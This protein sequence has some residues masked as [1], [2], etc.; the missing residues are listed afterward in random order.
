MWH[1]FAGDSDAAVR[2]HLKMLGVDVHGARAQSAPEARRATAAVDA[3]AKRNAITAVRLWQES[4]P[5]D[6][7]LGAR[8][9]ENR[10]IRPPWPGSL[11]YHPR[12]LDRDQQRPTLVAACTRLDALD[13]VN[14]VYRT[15]LCPETGCKA[16]GWTP[17][18]GIDVPKWRC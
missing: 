10:G 11:R 16:M 18:D 5:L 4:E 9:L 13:Q 14:A 3:R 15:F 8:Y 7:T 17:P 6:G 1:S 12:C 2:A